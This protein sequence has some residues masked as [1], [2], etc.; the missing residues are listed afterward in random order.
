MFNVP[1]SGM[2]TVMTPND[3]ERTKLLSVINI[4]GA[5][6]YSFP[7][8]LI[9]FLMELKNKNIA[10]LV[11]AD[12]GRVYLSSAIIFSVLG[13]ICIFLCFCGTRE[14]VPQNERKP[15]F[16][17]SVLYLFKN[18]PLLLLMLSNLLAFP[19]TLQAM[20]QTYVATYLM[21]G[22]EKIVM[23]G[24]PLMM[25]QLVGIMLVPAYIKKFGYFKTYVGHIIL[26]ML[27]FS[28][29]FFIGFE[30]VPSVIF[31]SF[32]FTLTTSPLTVIGGLFVADCVDYME[33]KT[34]QRTE[35]ISYALS[36]FNGKVV[37]ALQ[38]FVIG[39]LLAVFN[40]AEPQMINGLLVEQVQSPATRQGIWAIYTL[41]PSVG[42]IFSIIPMA[43]YPLKDSR[44][45]TIQA[46]LK[47][48][49]KENDGK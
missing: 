20:S 2:V 11:A 28:I 12:N 40:Y 8:L 46:E 15:S 41:I 48:R 36:S 25:G 44:M 27:P 24:A 26:S 4:L 39:I 47:E 21:G 23:L 33:W 16:K 49:R 31:F 9:P 38:A 14:R 18:K 19:R 35:G 6:S 43:F 22:A 1:Y 5:V 3:T 42:V 34:G 7:F 32:L 29:E 45:K 30:N 17:E 10:P 13:G 37:A